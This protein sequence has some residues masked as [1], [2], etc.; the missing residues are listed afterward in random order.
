MSDVIEYGEDE[1]EDDDVYDEDDEIR[2]AILEAESEKVWL[3]EPGDVDESD[4]PVYPLLGMFSAAGGMGIPFPGVSSND[5]NKKNG[6]V[7]DEVTEN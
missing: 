7:D 6:K 3:E 1:F 4:M 2:M 5:K